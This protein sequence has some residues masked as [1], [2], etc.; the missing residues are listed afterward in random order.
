MERG[1]GGKREGRI[2]S[3]TCWSVPEA[4]LGSTFRIYAL[5]CSRVESRRERVFARERE[6][7]KVQ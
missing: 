4:G 3:V 7:A 2:L 5:P 6:G 1:A